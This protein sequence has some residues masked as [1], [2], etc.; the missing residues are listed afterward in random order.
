MSRAVRIT[1]GSVLAGVLAFVAIVAGA[2]SA[3]SGAGPG[4]FDGLSTEGLDASATAEVLDV[5][6]Y[7]DWPTVDVR[8][9]TPDGEV[10]V[11]YVDWEWTPDLPAVGD[12]VEVVYD[13][14]DPEYAFAADDPYVED[15][16][17]SAPAGP[18]EEEASADEPDDG[19]LARTAGWVALGA[20]LGLVVTAVVTVVAAVR[21]PAPRPRTDAY[22]GQPYPGAPF[23]G[24]AYA[25]QTYAGPAY[26]G[27]AYAGQA[28]AYA[29][30]AYAG[31]AYAGQ[32]Y[33][34]QAYAAPAHGGQQPDAGQEHPQ[35]EGHPQPARTTGAPD[36]EQWSNPG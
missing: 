5:D 14:A 24:Q 7:V 34:G 26:A 29:G 10:V 32:A 19:G 11:T 15:G 9:T 22:A 17:G 30:Q 31:Q 13:P 35:Q 21:A 12:Q 23:P 20:L 25:G 6:D 33:A 18:G 4:F 1:V 3:G 16:A 28:T 27:Q 8:W 36:G 2:M